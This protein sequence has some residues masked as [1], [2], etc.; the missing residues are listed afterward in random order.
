M[1]DGNG[2]R[3]GRDRCS[4]ELNASGKTDM[5]RGGEGPEAHGGIERGCGAASGRGNEAAFRSHF[6]TAA[7]PASEDDGTTGRCSFAD[8]NSEEEGLSAQGKGTAQARPAALN[9]DGCVG[10]GVRPADPAFDGLAKFF[11]H[12]FSPPVPETVCSA[13]ASCHLHRALNRFF[14]SILSSPCR[15][16]I[17][18]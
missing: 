16:L 6:N 8:G 17:L 10:Y 1:S 2:L 13:R 15:V 3:T 12:A 18:S 14:L 11:D 5:S 9:R 4:V 7:G